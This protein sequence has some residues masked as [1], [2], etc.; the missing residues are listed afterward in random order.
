MYIDPGQFLAYGLIMVGIGIG[1]GVGL[2]LLWVKRPSVQVVEEGTDA[3]EMAFRTG[4][5]RTVIPEAF[6]EAF[7]DEL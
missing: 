7:E 4:P 5:H 3:Y 6:Y 1:V 2:C